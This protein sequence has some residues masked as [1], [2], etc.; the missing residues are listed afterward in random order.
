MGQRAN[1]VIVHNGQYQLYYNHW[2][3][4]TMPQDIFWGPVHTRKFIELQEH[5]TP[6]DW[7]NDIWAEGG[8][9]MDIDRQHVLFFGGED[10]LY[11]IQLRNYFI[12][13][14]A[15]PWQ[16]WSIAWAEEGIA[17]LAQ[18]VGVPVET[19]LAESS[20]P[21]NKL[22]GPVNVSFLSGVAG[23][24][25]PN[26]ET[27]LFLLDTDL[28]CYLLQGEALIQ[29]LNPAF[30]QTTLSWQEIEVND[31]FPSMGMYIDIS[32]R[33]LSFW[34]A[35]TMPGFLAKVQ[36]SWAGWDVSRFTHNYHSQLAVT[37]DCLQI[38]EREPNEI[39]DELAA[40]L[41]RNYSNPLQSFSSVIDQLQKQGHDLDINPSALSHTEYT[42][43]PELK[44]R[45]FQQALLAVQSQ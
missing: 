7:M 10:I 44:Q 35:E 29:N 30:G 2:C 27:L 9:V 12:R 28:G 5:V 8:V 13:L 42:L 20:A 38:K 31:E 26:G 18:Y 45:I 34:H 25:L 11:D 6:N 15:I 24:Q 41:L 37:G 33:K 4:N 39:W 22:F 17:D 43:T 16:G 36:T 40:L 3:A 32:A 21:T 23:I 1:L 14:M 19:V